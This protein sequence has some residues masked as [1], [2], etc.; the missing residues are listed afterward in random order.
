MVPPP[1]RARTPAPELGRPRTRTWGRSRGTITWESGHHSPQPWNRWRRATWGRGEG[2][3]N[4]DVIYV[5]IPAQNHAGTVG[6]LL[7]KIRQVF[8]S[9]PREYHLLVAIDGATDATADVLKS[10]QRVLPLSVTHHET[11]RGYAATLEGLLQEA[12]RRTD[13]PRRD[14]LITLRPDFSVSPGVM[15]QLIKRIESG[16]DVVV[17]DAI[18][19]DPSL[20]GR[21]VR[22]LANRLL[23]PG[24]HVPGVRDLL[25]GICALRM[26]T[27]KRCVQER[28]GGLFETEGR[29][30]NAELIARAASHAR[31]IALVRIE[32]S[33]LRPA[34]VE[35]V[36]PVPLALALLRAGRRVRIPQPS[37]AVK[38]AS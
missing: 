35:R 30:A 5:C 29:L 3:L 31:Q 7:W 6:L 19:G 34:A 13:R 1:E 26:S 11:P 20:A 36:P 10:Y 14:L 28:S 27:I 4:R 32:P 24:V 15:P 33:H 18:E 9:H 23:R 37:V 25:S 38:R 17:G 21:V 12:L 22:R 8:A 2:R 16:A